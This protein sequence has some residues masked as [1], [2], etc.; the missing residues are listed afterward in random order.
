MRQKEGQLHHH[1]QWGPQPAGVPKW[2]AGVVARA[3]PRSAIF[4]LLYAKGVQ[5][6]TALSYERAQRAPMARWSG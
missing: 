3:I 2:P 5:A 1:W 4:N 6:R